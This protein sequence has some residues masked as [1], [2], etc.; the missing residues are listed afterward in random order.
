MS[1]L[2]RRLDRIETQADARSCQTCHDHPVRLEGRD[3]ITGEESETMPE[4]GCPDCG[5]PVLLTY[6]LPF[7]VRELP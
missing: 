1:T 7:D 6:D 3:P 5:H 4:T 2:R